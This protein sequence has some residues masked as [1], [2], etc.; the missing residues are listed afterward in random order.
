MPAQ[1]FVKTSRFHELRAHFQV[2]IWALD[3]MAK[4]FLQQRG[5]EAILATSSYLLGQHLELRRGEFLGPHLIVYPHVGERRC[6][7]SL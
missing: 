2:F 7:G 5:G 6:N 3:K 4:C 1:E